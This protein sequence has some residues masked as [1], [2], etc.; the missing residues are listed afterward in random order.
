MTIYILKYKIKSKYFDF[1]REQ[2]TL[3][4]DEESLI[5]FLINNISKIVSYAIYKKISVM[6]II[7][8]LK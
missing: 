6:E 5:R 7:D 8:F 1:T 4:Y 3:F 2:E